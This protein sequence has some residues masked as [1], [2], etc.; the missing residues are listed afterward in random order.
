MGLGNQTH[1]QLVPF[2]LFVLSLAIAISSMLGLNPA[3]AAEPVCANPAVWYCGDFEDGTLNG[4]VFSGG[5]GN[6][7][8]NAFNG[9][10]SL[11]ASYGIVPRSGDN[12]GSGYGLVKRSD[13]RSGSTNELHMRWYEYFTPN[14]V[15]SQIAT[16]GFMISEP[17][18]ARIMYILNDGWATGGRKSLTDY[19]EQTNQPGNFFDNRDSFVWTGANLGRWVQVEVHVKLNTS[20]SNGTYRQWVNG[21]LTREYYTVN[22]GNHSSIGYFEISGYWNCLNTD[23]TTSGN[24]HPQMDR[25]IDNIVIADGDFMIGPVGGTGTPLA[26][27]TNLRVSQ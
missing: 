27:P 9:T 18:G 24:S 21:T 6:S 19:G 11:H 22:Y 7:T 25:Y 1:K 10:H 3:H 17:S 23:C 12:G 8:A 5:W 2:C 16:K 4:F 13:Y 14:W 26:P 20:G 15:W